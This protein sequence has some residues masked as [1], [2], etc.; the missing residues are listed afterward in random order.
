MLTGIFFVG[1]LTPQ[2]TQADR[3]NE[4]NLK[5]ALVLNLARFTNWPDDHIS[6][7]NETLRFCVFG[8]DLV[9]KSFSR[10]DKKTLG[11]RVIKTK[12]LTNPS[13][14]NKCDVLFYSG[15][16]R[17]LLSRVLAA[18]D[19][20]PILTIGEMRGFTHVGGAINMVRKNSKIHFE[21]NTVNV[22][23]SHLSVSSRLLKLC[24]IV[25]N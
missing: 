19:K 21:I 23:K 15:K 8:E 4:Y 3:A 22:N 1:V 18:T 20:L 5:A 25:N 13:H 14:A 12:A 6:Y 2:N 11:N 7:E 16:N 9:Q 17:L 24:K 10:I